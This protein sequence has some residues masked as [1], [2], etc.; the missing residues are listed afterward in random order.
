MMVL[1]RTYDDAIIMID[2][3]M[4]MMLEYVNLL[5]EYDSKSVP[6]LPQKDNYYTFIPS[7][8]VFIGGGGDRYIYIYIYIPLY[9]PPIQLLLLL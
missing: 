5:V 9:L 3:V 8:Y 1:V 7:S 4:M 6:T 2:I